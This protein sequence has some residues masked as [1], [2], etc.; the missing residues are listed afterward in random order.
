M[1]SMPAS[2]SARQMTL[3]PR[4]WPSRPGLAIRT[5]VFFSVISSSTR[6]GSKR[7]RLLVFSVDVFQGIHDFSQGRIVLDGLQ[8]KRHEVEVID[9]RLLEIGQRLFNSGPRPAL[10]HR[11]KAGDRLAGHGLVDLEERN[12]FVFHL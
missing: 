2:R 5:L 4:S 7:H 1:T 12:L 9:R 10:P 8:E 11:T 6:P 3:A